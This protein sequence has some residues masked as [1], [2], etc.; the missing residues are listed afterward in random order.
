M[1]KLIDMDEGKTSVCG[2]SNLPVVIV[3]RLKITI[4]VLGVAHKTHVKGAED[5]NVSIVL[6]LDEL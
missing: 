2:L 6:V 1:D 5:T 3:K 4:D